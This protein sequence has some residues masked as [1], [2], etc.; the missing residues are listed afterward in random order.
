DRHQPILPW[1][2]PEGV[3]KL[4]PVTIS[5]RF[6]EHLIAAWHHA[7]SDAPISDQQVVLT[8]RASFDASARELTREAALA[9]GLPADLVLFEEPQ[10]ALY[11]WLANR[12]EQWRRHLG[13]GDTLLV[14]DVGGGTTDFTLIGVDETD[15]ALELQRIAV[16][17][18]T[19]VG[20]DNMD[21]ALAHFS[22][23]AFAAKGLQL[24]A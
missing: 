15:G 10:A 24:D 17:P 13:V 21:V 20:G 12:G 1:N 23:A 14:C 22:S 5:Q 11:A 9:A 4:S 3:T 8:V 7:F 2:A 19:L 18:H 16:G 6:L